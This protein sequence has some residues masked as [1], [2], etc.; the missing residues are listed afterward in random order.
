MMVRTG[1]IFVF[2]LIA[3][4]TGQVCKEC[5]CEN[6]KCRLDA[7]E[8]RERDM[9]LDMIDFLKNKLNNLHSDC[10]TCDTCSSFKGCE[11]CGKVPNL[12][13]RSATTMDCD[14]CC[15][16]VPTPSPTN[17]P[18]TKAPTKPCPICADYDL[19]PNPQYDFNG[20]NDLANCCVETCAQCDCPQLFIKD[21]NMLN[22][23][24]LPQ[25]EC[26]RTC[27]KPTCWTYDCVFYGKQFNAANG[28]SLDFSA[29]V[30]CLDQPT[31]S[32][33]PSPTRADPATCAF[34]SPYQC[35]ADMSFNPNNAGSTDRR[36]SVCCREL[37]Q[38]WSVANCKQ[39][40]GYVLNPNYAISH[41]LTTDECCARTCFHYDCAFYNMVSNP[42]NI[43]S[44]HFHHHHCCK[45]TCATWGLHHCHLEGMTVKQNVPAQTTP[46]LATCC[47][48]S[49]KTWFSGSTSSCPPGEIVDSDKDFIPSNGPDHPEC[50][51]PRCS[52]VTEDSCHDIG[53]K[54]CEDE[55]IGTA[56]CVA[57]EN[58][59]DHT[60]FRN[61]ECC[62]CAEHGAYALWALDDNQY[63]CL[64]PIAREEDYYCKPK[65][66]PDN[67]KDEKMCRVEK[68]GQYHCHEFEDYVHDQ[69]DKDSSITESKMEPCCIT[70]WAADGSVKA[71]KP[72]ESCCL[73][74]PISC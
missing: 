27:C 38:T 16:D 5:D 17:S 22:M 7:I 66:N 24:P 43:N 6:T 25:G 30:C 19:F 1:I 36:E 58:C 4:A 65:K 35:P 50:C 46:S 69:Q 62:K 48:N 39:S 74:D 3:A 40:E 70:H 20:P 73:T 42:A 55:D 28:D 34:P 44:I 41:I 53:L 37:C 31:E 68:N 32:P 47:E 23:V 2:S 64:D 59:M 72:F 51:V 67:G 61:C 56:K 15:T 45:E 21:P 49:C 11:A 9:I 18:P 12:L 13:A 26:H 63:H 54:K 29:D 8:Q 57:P 10:P 60:D 33:S 14:T 71:P 52:L